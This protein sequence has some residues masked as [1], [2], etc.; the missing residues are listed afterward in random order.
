W[1]YPEK[2]LKEVTKG[3]RKVLVVEQSLGQMVEDVRAILPFKEVSFL[4]KA[5][6]GIPQ[7]KEIVKVIKK[8]L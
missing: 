6:G 8:N 7:A 2:G 3:I 1:P 4:G 5:G